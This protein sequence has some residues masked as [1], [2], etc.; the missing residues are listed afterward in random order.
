MKVLKKDCV[1]L[2]CY[3][4][5]NGSLML[6][7]SAFLTAWRVSCVHAEMRVQMAYR[8]AE[9][10]YVTVRDAI[11]IQIA[12]PGNGYNRKT[13]ESAQKQNSS[14]HPDYAHIRIRIMV[15]V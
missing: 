13:S 1:I 5:N 4:E 12:I 2:Y 14:Q 6:T 8:Q 11:S 3:V 15:G 9:S 7:R 10:T